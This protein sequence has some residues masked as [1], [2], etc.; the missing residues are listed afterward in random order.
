MKIKLS[1]Q[2]GNQV[3]LERATIQDVNPN[4]EKFD[5]ILL[6]NSI[7]H[8][9]EEACIK[10]QHD[11]KAKETYKTALRNICAL[12]NND[13]K[14]VIV[15]SSRY[16]FFALCKIKNPFAPTIEWEKH[17]SPMYWSRLLSDAG[18]HNP[19]IRWISFNRLGLIGKFLFGNIL[20][21]YFLDSYFCLTMEK[22]FPPS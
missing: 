4:N 3:R 14:L 7:N 5:I 1:L 17:Q 8:L 10:L 12:A 21:S 6:H 22:E 11:D 9:N 18:F 13:A 19:K 15:D 20:A 2:I 16:N